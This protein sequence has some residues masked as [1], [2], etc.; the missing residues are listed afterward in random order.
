VLTVTR[1]APGGEEV[2]LIANLTP[3]RQ[4]WSRSGG[5]I[6]LDSGDPRFGGGPEKPLAAFQALLLDTSR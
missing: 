3:R 6:L 2:Q 1:G 4:S 5:K